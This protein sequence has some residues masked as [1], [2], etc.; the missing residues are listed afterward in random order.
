[1]QDI[2][3]SFDD[4]CQNVNNNIKF[5]N[6]IGAIITFK[7]TNTALMLQSGDYLEDTAVSKFNLKI[8]SDN[9]GNIDGTVLFLN[10]FNPIP[11]GGG[12]L[13]PCGFSL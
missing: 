4:L 11:Y 10:I 8:S 5:D 12:I 3:H 7:T 1:M 9:I 2:I 6:D 13:S